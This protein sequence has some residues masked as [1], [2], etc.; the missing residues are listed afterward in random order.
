MR[1]RR[2]A[3]E[4]ISFLVSNPCIIIDVLIGERTYS[5]HLTSFLATDSAGGGIF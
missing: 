3:R 5:N 4:R 1:Y 2:L